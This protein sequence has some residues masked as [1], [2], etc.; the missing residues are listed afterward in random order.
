MGYASAL[1]WV[2]CIVILDG[3]ACDFQDILRVGL[4]RRAEVAVMGIRDHVPRLH[5]RRS[6]ASPGIIGIR[7][8]TFV[9]RVLAA[10][11]ILVFGCLILAPFLDDIEF[12][13][14]KTGDLRTLPRFPRPSSGR[15]TPRRLPPSPSQEQP[16]TP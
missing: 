10:S 4:L 6:A 7:A 16:G 1:A 15:T 3:Y 12:S 5:V 8:R 9:L 13:L 2:L 11:L 14:R